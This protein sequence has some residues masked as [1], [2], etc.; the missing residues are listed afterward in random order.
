MLES[1]VV[2]MPFG[3]AIMRDGRI[4]MKFPT[5]QEAYEYKKELEDLNNENRTTKKYSYQDKS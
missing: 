5:E 1:D 2:I 3:A 4:I